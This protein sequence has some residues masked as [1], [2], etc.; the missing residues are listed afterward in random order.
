MTYKMGGLF[1]KSSSCSADYVSL[2]T[3]KLHFVTEV[4]D[5]FGQTLVNVTL[6]LIHGCQTCNPQSYITWPPVLPT[7]LRVTHRQHA[8]C[9]GQPCV[10][11]KEPIPDCVLEHWSGCHKQ[12]SFRVATDPCRTA[13]AAAAPKSCKMA[14]WWL[15]QDCTAKSAQS[16]SRRQGKSV[17]LGEFDTPTLIELVILCNG[18]TIVGPI[19]QFYNYFFHVLFKHCLV[20]KDFLFKSQRMNEI[21]TWRIVPEKLTVA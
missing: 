9:S 11:H 19:P 15:E 17:S 6:S 1:K 21:W 3:V 8:E 12:H 18:L 20:S 10:L 2:I 14:P 7:G 5:S 4:N 13:I 16:R